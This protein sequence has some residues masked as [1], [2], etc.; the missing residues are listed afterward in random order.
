MS[1]TIRVDGVKETIADLRRLDPQIRKAFNK[2]AKAIATPVIRVA[3]NRYRGLQFPSGTYRNWQQGGRE[4]FPLNPSKAAKAIRLKISTS[5]KNASSIFIV[6][7]YAGAGVFE[8]ARNGSLG[9]AFNRKNG[10]PARVMWPSVETSESA[11]AEEMARLVEAV[12]DQI[13]KEL[14]L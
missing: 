3:Q 10:A 14:S 9:E 11:V 5:K 12:S 1:A 6:N 7:T 8:F 13:N 4:I 2:D